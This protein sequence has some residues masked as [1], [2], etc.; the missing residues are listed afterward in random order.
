M[1]ANRHHVRLV[2]LALTGVDK[3]A[4]ELVPLHV[5]DDVH[6]LERQ[7]R[8]QAILAP[9]ARSGGVLEEDAD[10]VDLFDL[11]RHA[12]AQVLLQILDRAL[13]DLDEAR[14]I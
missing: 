6:D 7:A 13:M 8:V 2:D 14:T 9:S 4:A 11:F 10:I 1:L 5:M 12:V 3:H